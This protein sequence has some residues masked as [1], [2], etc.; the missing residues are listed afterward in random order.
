MSEQIYKEFFEEA[1]NQIKSEYIE[2]G[3]E[4]DFNFW[5]NLEYLEDTIESIT[6][7]VP[8][9][10]MWK[11]MVKNGTATKIQEKINELTAQEIKLIPV[12]KNSK[13][14]STSQNQVSNIQQTFDKTTIQNQES[15]YSNPY[16]SFQTQQKETFLQSTKNENNLNDLPLFNNIEKQQPQTTSQKSSRSRFEQSMAGLKAMIEKQKEIEAQEQIQA[17]NQ[18]SIKKQTSIFSSQENFYSNQQSQIIQPQQIS[19]SNLDD[20]YQR[21]LNEEVAKMKKRTIQINHPLLR[22]DYTFENFIPGANSQYA[23]SVAKR[24]AETPG[25]E[26][27]NPILFYGGVGLG[28][29]HLMQSIG[30]QIY[31]NNPDAKIR[32]ISAEAFTN[33]FTYSI[34]SKK[35]EEFKKKYRNLDVLLLDDIQFLAGKEATQEELFH[36]FNS[37]YD[38][39]GQLVFTCDRPITEIQKLTDRLRTRFTRG[40]NIDLQPPD[41]ETRRAILEKKINNSEKKIPSDVID[42]I[43]QY[44]QSNVRDLEACLKTITSYCELIKQD[45]TLDV[46]KNLLKDKIDENAPTGAATVESIQKAVAKHYGLRFS[47]L[48]GKKKSKQYVLP[49]QVAIYIT[50]KLMAEYSLKDIGNEF[51]GRDHTTI[52]SAIERIELLIKTKP[53]IDVIVKQL[54][55]DSHEIK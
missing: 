12:A 33:E 28:K 18:D 6:I 54:I 38:R 21:M 25:V 3:K 51:G 26:G 34:Q 15:Q 5:F 45:L 36:T 7:K 8:S 47:D 32:Y 11:Q 43:A 55:K 31:T 53:E 46:A 44:I 16:Q 9:D 42:Y 10:F 39:K 49:R 52:I 50:R 29:T 27:Y 4:K 24:A 35:T 1:L 37:I 30:N 22:D 41:Y 40:L 23:Y 2:L 20:D 17:Q 13:A 48:I 19:S 14:I